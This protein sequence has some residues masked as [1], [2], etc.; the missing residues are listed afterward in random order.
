MLANSMFNIAICAA[1]NIKISN[2]PKITSFLPVALVLICCCV[3]SL[4]QS[5]AIIEYIIY[6]KWQYCH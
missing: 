4:L 6:K 2:V 1:P 5:Y 3:L